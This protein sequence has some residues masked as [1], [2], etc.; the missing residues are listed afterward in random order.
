MTN[1]K[2]ESENHSCDSMRTYLIR[3][4]SMFDLG[5]VATDKKK[6]FHHEAGNPSVAPSIPQVV[7]G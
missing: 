2:V 1:G 7:S 3:T 5:I 6:N 4:M